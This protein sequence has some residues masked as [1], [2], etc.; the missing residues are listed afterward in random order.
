MYWSML[1][2]QQLEPKFFQRT[3][4]ISKNRNICTKLTVKH[5]HMEL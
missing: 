5:I 1:P 4:G 2:K 3:V